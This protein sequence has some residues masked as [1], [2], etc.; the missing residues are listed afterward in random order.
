MRLS[1]YRRCQAENN[2]QK[3][4]LTALCYTP[5]KEGESMVVIT[6]PFTPSRHSSRVVSPDAD[7]TGGVVT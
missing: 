3:I 6:V 7:R 5:N 4:F 1:I 2:L